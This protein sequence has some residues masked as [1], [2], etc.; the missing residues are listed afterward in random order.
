MKVR[1]RGAKPSAGCHLL[2]PCHSPHRRGSTFPTLSYG[3]AWQ[4][5]FT[6]DARTFSL[7]WLLPFGWESSLAADSLTPD[8]GCPAG[9]MR[10]LSLD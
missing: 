4:M 5:L 8:K 6:G 1:A 2:N 3:Q 10:P 9:R 7:A